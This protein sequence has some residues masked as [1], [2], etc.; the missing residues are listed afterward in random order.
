M[1]LIT[2]QQRLHALGLSSVAK[3]FESSEKGWCEMVYSL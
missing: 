2:V 1:V 3:N